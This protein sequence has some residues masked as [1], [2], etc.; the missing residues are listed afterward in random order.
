MSPKNT[1]TVGFSLFSTDEQAKET[2]RRGKKEVDP[3]KPK[4]P[5]SAY[6]RFTLEKRDAVKAE[7]PGK[8]FFFADNLL[9]FYRI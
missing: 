6:F 3:D 2:K 7:N 4:K 9:P 5:L 1:N 8:L